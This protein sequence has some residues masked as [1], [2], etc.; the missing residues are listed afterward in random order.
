MKIIIDQE[1]IFASPYATKF[2]P[3]SEI[4][5]DII[6]VTLHDNIFSKKNADSLSKSNLTGC[7]VNICNQLDRITFPRDSLIEYAG[8]S[9]TPFIS[10]AAFKLKKMGIQL[11][12][13]SF[14]HNYRE[15]DSE[16]NG[17]CIMPDAP[18][19]NKTNPV[20]HRVPEKLN[21]LHRN[22]EC[23]ITFSSSFLIDKN[24]LYGIK[25]ICDTFEYDVRCPGVD[26]IF[27]KETAI[28]FAD[29]VK[30]NIL[31]IQSQN[32]NCIERIHLVVSAS[33]SMTFCLA[34]KLIEPYMP[35]LSI[36]HYDSHAKIKRSWGIDFSGGDYSV[37]IK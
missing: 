22:G 28:A 20:L 23:I 32:S 25:T 19:S 15:S 11:E 35:P 4:D 16:L 26:S 30:K 8:V 5:G 24:N 12:E 17:W 14:W 27:T 31:T 2:R 6:Q 7:A 36:Y 37:F 34:Y 1:C 9:D 21:C 18:T 13:I 3:L 33:V 29:D 10:L